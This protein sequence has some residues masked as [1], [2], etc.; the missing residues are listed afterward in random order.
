MKTRKQKEKFNLK[1]LKMYAGKVI[2]FKSLSMPNKLAI[3]WY[4]AVDGCAWDNSMFIL[5]SSN[6][7]LKKKL[8]AAINNYYDE[9]YGDTKF[10]VINIPVEVCKQEVMKHLKGDFKTFEDYHIWYMNDCG[11][12]K[13]TKK[14]AWP[15]I[16]S[17]F[18]DEFFQDGWHRFHRYIELK[19]SKIPCICYF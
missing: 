15:C 11:V 16:L 3:S 8:K 14:D 2:Y 7:Q 6:V 13:H 10:G 12:D 17:D 4:M 18:D 9:T 19:M 1:L 5:T